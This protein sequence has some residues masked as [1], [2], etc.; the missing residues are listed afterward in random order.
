FAKVLPLGP[1]QIDGEQ[2]GDGCA[3]KSPR[4]KAVITTDHNQPRSA[5]NACFECPPAWHVEREGIDV[6]ENVNIVLALL[7]IVAQVFAF[8]FIVKSFARDDDIGRCRERSANE[9]LFDRRL[10]S[11]AGRADEIQHADSSLANGDESARLVVRGNLLSFTRF[12]AEGDFVLSRLSGRV[13]QAD[14]QRAALTVESN[15]LGIDGDH[16]AL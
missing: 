3:E 2:T 4:A 16:V 8:L 15:I 10:A 1:A 12:D 7:E 14:R 13:F 9:S 11:H 5:A 6:V